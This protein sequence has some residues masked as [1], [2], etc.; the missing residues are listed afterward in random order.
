MF[1]STFIVMILN[2]TSRLLGLIREMIIGSLFGATGLTD[3]Y[4]SATRIPNFFT[5]LFGEGSLGTVFIPIYNKSIK[6]EGKTKTDEFVFSV[7]NF[8]IAFTSTISIMM[9]IFSEQIL[10]V[11]TAFKDIERFKIANS[12]L[13]IVA[14]YFLFIALA[15][16][17]SSLLNNY[18]KFI[19]SSSMGIA[20][21]ITIICV[22]ILTKDYFGIFG[23]GMA[24]ILSGIVQLFILL[25]DFFKIMKTYKFIIDF[26]NIYVKEM[27]KLMFPTL[28]GIFGY[29]INEIID[30]RFATLLPTGTVSALNYASRLYL[31]PIGIFAIS[32]SVVIFP[33]L[34]KSVI[35]ENKKKTKDIIEKGLYILNFLIIPSIIILYKY[36]LEIVTLIYKRGNFSERAVVITSEILK[37]Y[38]LGLL[39]FSTIHLLTRSHYVYKNR[40][41]P[42]KSSFI[43]IFIN[44]FLDYI[45]YKEY[46][47]IGLTIAT[48]FSAMI[49]Y[50]ILFYS[51]NRRYVTINL[52]KYILNILLCLLISINSYIITEKFIIFS[53]GNYL[54]LI[55]I[56]FFA[57]IYIIQWSVLFILKKYKDNVLN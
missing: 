8:I 46:K 25:P 54:I 55:K 19:I 15:G 45:L 44:I 4:I 3:A 18:K 17:V 28:I 32:L 47:H 11:T 21:N 33:E 49:N 34:S 9:I 1:K 29:Q 50:F 36:S 23:L 39:F 14:F 38:A 56:L 37:F 57:L 13:K 16:V 51:L 7:L 10:S 22:T 2:M 20:F 26:N 27:F 52:L 43:A 42:V 41:I 30:N 53:L 5:T 40:K 24:Y 31:L 35:N 6:D 48:S 12:M